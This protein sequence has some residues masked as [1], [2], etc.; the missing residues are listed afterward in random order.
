MSLSVEQFLQLL[1]LFA[2]LTP[3]I[4]FLTGKNNLRKF[5]WMAA[6]SPNGQRWA[7]G[8][9]FILIVA[10]GIAV[11]AFTSKNGTIPTIIHDDHS[12]YSTTII[13]PQDDKAHVP[14]EVPLIPKVP[15]RK[16]FNTDIKIIVRIDNERND[17]FSDSLAAFYRKR[18]YNA[19]VGSVPGLPAGNSIIGNLSAS[20]VEEGVIGTQHYTNYKIKLAL[21][22]Y[23]GDDTSPCTDRVYEQQMTLRANGSKETLLEQGFWELLNKIKSA[24]TTPVCL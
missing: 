13:K 7:I 14:Q 4:I 11:V 1:G 9:I 20:V 24:P 21:T 18:G 23:R 22:V 10:V 3:G 16:T 5:S 12:Q 19:T 17:V 6:M 15:S 8:I 2:V